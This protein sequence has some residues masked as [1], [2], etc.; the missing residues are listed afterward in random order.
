MRPFMSQYWVLWPFY[1]DELARVGH[2]IPNEVFVAFQQLLHVKINQSLVKKIC[3]LRLEIDIGTELI[4][5]LLNF[6][7]I[8]SYKLKIKRLNFEVKKR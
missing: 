5:L 7:T 2:C 3:S 4:P 6:F 8:F 1:D